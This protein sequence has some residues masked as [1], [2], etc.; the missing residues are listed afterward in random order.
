M[1]RVLTFAFFIL[2]VGRGAALAPAAGP[3]DN[4]LLTQTFNQLMD[5]MT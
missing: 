1:Y 4:T 3:K 5:V 2:G